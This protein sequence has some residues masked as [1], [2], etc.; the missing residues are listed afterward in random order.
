MSALQAFSVGVIGYGLGLG[1]SLLFCARYVTA[2]SVKLAFYMPWPVLIV[3]A[4]SMV[5][6][7][8]TF[9][10]F[11]VGRVLV[12]EPAIV[13]RVIS[14]LTN[15]SVPAAISSSAMAAARR[16]CWPCAVLILTCYRVR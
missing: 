3:T 15:P 10:L 14:W 13:F 1:P 7:V 4:V 8:V 11:S 6:I 12:E 2:H 9:S 5:M 16:A